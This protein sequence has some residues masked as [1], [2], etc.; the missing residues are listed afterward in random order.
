MSDFSLDVWPA[1]Y[2]FIKERVRLTSGS[3]CQAAFKGGPWLPLLVV[4]IEQ[5]IFTTIHHVLVDNL[6]NKS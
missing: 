5:N 1:G 6:I 3:D 4:V 2:N